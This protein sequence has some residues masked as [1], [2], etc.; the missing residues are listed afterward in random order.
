[1]VRC[2]VSC[3]EHVGHLNPTLPV[4]KA[5]VDLGHEAGVPK[6]LEFEGTKGVLLVSDLE[7]VVLAFRATVLLLDSFKAFSDT[8]TA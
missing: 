7:V 5:L 8:R 1:M 6:G 3:S 2:L 4:V